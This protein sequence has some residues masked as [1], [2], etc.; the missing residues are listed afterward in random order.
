L[1]KA[2]SF[3]VK[4]SWNAEGDETT[5]ARREP[6]QREKTLPC[7]WD[8]RWRNRWRGRS[9]R[10]RLPIMGRGGGPGGRFLCF[11]WKKSLKMMR[12]ERRKKREYVNNGSVSM[13]GYGEIVE[14]A[15]NEHT[16][17]RCVWLVNVS[18]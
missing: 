1:A 10:L 9:R 3:L 15:E 7:V 5:T 16:I 11:V 17:R 8:M 6:N 13:A 14:F 4:H 12:R 2:T 18:M